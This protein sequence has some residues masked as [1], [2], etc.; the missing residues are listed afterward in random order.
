MLLPILKIY[1]KN[2]RALIGWNRVH[3]SCN[4]SAKLSKFRLPSLW[5]MLFFM[6]IIT[7]II[8]LG[9]LN[10]FSKTTNCTCH[11]LRAREIFGL[12]QIYSILTPNF[13]QN[14][15]SSNFLCYLQVVPCH[16]W[17]RARFHI[18]FKRHA[19]RVGQVRHFSMKSCVKNTSKTCHEDFSLK[20]YCELS[21]EPSPFSVKAVRSIL[22]EEQISFIS[23]VA[24]KL[25]TYMKTSI[26]LIGSFFLSQILLEVKVYPSEWPSRLFLRS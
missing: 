7:N 24:R 14:H 3:L 8:S 4:T 26:R 15:V 5:K 13:T 18:R 19:R 17:L 21:R 22:L 12:W 11:L 9:T 10:K 20:L 1:T 25:C 16:L 23:C 2:L 6:Y